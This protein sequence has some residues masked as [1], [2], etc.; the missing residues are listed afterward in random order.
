MAL[1][2]TNSFVY[3]RFDSIWSVSHYAF[4]TYVRVVRTEGNFKKAFSVVRV[5]PLLPASSLTRNTRNTR[6]R[7]QTEGGLLIPALFRCY[8]GFIPLLF[9]CYSP[10]ILLLFPCYSPA[11]LLLFSCYSP[12]IPLLFSCYSPAILALFRLYSFMPALYAGLYAVRNA[13]C[14][15][16]RECVVVYITW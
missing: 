9:S 11:I 6:R 12:A 5:P 2:G 15:Q 13:R 3:L 4:F 7:Q 14:R 8:D 1:L 16:R 10:A